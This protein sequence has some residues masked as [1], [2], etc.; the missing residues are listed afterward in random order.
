MS[1]DEGTHESRSINESEDDQ[2][3]KLEDIPTIRKLYEDSVLAAPPQDRIRYKPNDS[4]LDRISLY[5]GDITQLKVDAIVNAANKSLL[6]GGGVDGAIHRAAGPHLLDE[7]RTLNGC[8]TGESKITRGYN[9]PARHVIHTVGPVYSPPE[10]EEKARQLASCYRTSLEVAVENEIRHIA[11]PSISTGVYGYP[12]EDATHIALGTVR[13]FIESE[14]ASKLERSIFVVWS[15][16]DREVYERLIPEYFPP[17][18]TEPQSKES[19]S[20]KAS[21]AASAT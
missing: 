15:D 10:V 4:L 18:E 21:E 1:S 19:R 11:F 2:I 20:E 8:N 7:C 13:Q 6:G 14:R 16:K 3:V 17:V 5:Q 9:L 12:I